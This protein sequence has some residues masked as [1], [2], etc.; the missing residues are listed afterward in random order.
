LKENAGVCESLVGLD[1]P[2]NENAGVDVDG[3]VL[4]PPP[5][6]PNLKLEVPV[7]AA[8]AVVEPAPNLKGAGSLLA[9]GAFVDEEPK[10]KA[11]F[12]AAGTGLESIV[13]ALVVLT[14]SGTL[15]NPPNEAAVEP[16]APVDENA[17]GDTFGASVTLTSSGFFSF[18]APEVPPKPVNDVV[19]GTDVATEVSSFFSSLVLAPNAKLPTVLG[20]LGVVDVVAEA[21]GAKE[22]GA[23][24]IELVPVL[25]EDRNPNCDVGLG[26]SFAVS[27]T[28]FVAPKVATG[29]LRVDLLSN[30]SDSTEGF[31]D[32]PKLKDG[33][34]AVVSFSASDVEVDLTV[35]AA[36]EP[37]E[38]KEK[39]GLD[40]ADSVDR[41]FCSVDVVLAVDAGVEPNAKLVFFLC[42]R[43][44]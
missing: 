19:A 33:F 11:G 43:G 2:E 10:V 24:V 4:A 6:P 34:D 15:P 16:E 9:A 25:A 44:R 32:E 37:A 17:G 21:F 36:V 26:V 13:V 20:V 1:T 23:G 41:V 38:P 12:V 22:R 5:P 7:L 29:N 31:V 27:V 42:R 39:E 30:F 14:L 18:D 8:A 35:A 40:T 28:V 3:V